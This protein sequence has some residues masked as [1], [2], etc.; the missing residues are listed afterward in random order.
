VKVG[1]SV[2]GKPRRSRLKLLFVVFVLYCFVISNVCRR[3]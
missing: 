1:V 2:N 3:F